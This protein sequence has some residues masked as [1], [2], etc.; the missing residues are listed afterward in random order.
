MGLSFANK[1]TVSEL[2]VRVFIY[3]TENF[4]LGNTH[5]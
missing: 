4:L 5:R 3:V 1:F 2:Q